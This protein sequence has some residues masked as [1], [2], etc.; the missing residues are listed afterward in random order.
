MADHSIAG[1]WLGHYRY[2]KFPAHGGGGF[3]AFFSETSGAIHGTIV[4]D[5]GAGKATLTGTFSFPDIQ[6]IKL[7]VKQTQNKSVKKEKIV[8][9]KFQIGFAKFGIKVSEEQTLT[10]TTT[11]TFGN[12]VEYKGTMSEDGKSLSGTW[13]IQDDKNSTSGTWTANRLKEDDVEEEIKTNVGRVK[14]KEKPE[15]V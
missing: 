13:K 2:D 8:K 11:E 4:D 3:T 14:E 5:G 10:T 9:P 7:Y 1:E 6:F 12:P 15:T